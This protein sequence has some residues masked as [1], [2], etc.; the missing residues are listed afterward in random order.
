VA[1]LNLNQMEKIKRKEE[2]NSKVKRK[3]KVA[4]YPRPLGLS[5]HQAQL[6]RAPS[7][8]SSLC[9]AGPTCRRSRFT[10][11]AP[12]PSL[13]LPVGPARQPRFPRAR[14]RFLLSLCA[15]GP[16]CQLRR[17]RVTA[18]E[19]RAPAFSAPTSRVGSSPQPRPRPLEPRT[20]LALSPSLI[21]APT[22]P[23][24][25]PL[26]RCAHAK[27]PSPRTAAARACSSV[28]VGAP[29]CPLPR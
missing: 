13:S 9:A 7:R 28:A 21:C 22:G 3:G 19:P 11:R 5:A 24:S 6:A 4:R 18:A 16:D 29:P 1:H 23:L 15:V 26:P 14:T 17:S 20:S 27:S 12:S 8:P 25:R 10:A 2:G